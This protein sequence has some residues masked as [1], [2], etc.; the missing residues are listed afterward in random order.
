MH[1]KA[2]CYSSAG[3]SIA[4]YR[5]WTILVAFFKKADS[6][7]AAP[8]VQDRT[9]VTAAIKEHRWKSGYFEMNSLDG[10]FMD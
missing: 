10:N 1:G 4:H 9:T 2:D 7:K 5:H 6:L 8:S 3:T